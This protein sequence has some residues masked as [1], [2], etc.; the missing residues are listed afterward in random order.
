MVSDETQSVM[1]RA[2]RLYASQLQADLEARHTGRFVAI[3]PDSGEYFLGD[4]FDE[5]V[6][7][8]RT[9][10]PFRLSHT[11]RIGHRAAFKLAGLQQQVRGSGAVLA[12]EIGAQ[13]S[14]FA[15]E[16]RRTP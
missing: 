2:K 9:K 15:A 10:Y 7:H 16:R 12:R 1:D 14:R 8:A 5:A 4:T 13:G 6:K 11:I 3:E